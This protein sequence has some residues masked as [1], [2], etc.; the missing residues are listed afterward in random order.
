MRSKIAG[1]FHSKHKTQSS[2]DDK[3]YCALWVCAFLSNSWF[4]YNV[5]LQKNENLIHNHHYNINKNKINN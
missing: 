3:C 2:H 5:P 4:T 1:H